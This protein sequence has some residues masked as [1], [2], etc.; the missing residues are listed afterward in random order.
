MSTIADR[1]DRNMASKVGPSTR[2]VP[3]FST[4]FPQKTG[5]F[6]RIKLPFLVPVLVPVF[7]PGRYVSVSDIQNGVEPVECVSHTTNGALLT[8]SDGNELHSNLTQRDSSV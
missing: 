1:R 6:F 5:T 7:V 8:Q 2:L 4:R 3:V